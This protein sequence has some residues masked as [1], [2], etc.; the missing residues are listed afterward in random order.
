MDYNNILRSENHKKDSLVTYAVSLHFPQEI[1]EIVISTVKSISE[2]TGNSFIIENKIPPHITIGAFHASKQNEK[3]LL[4]LVEEFS[5]L[6][7]QV[8]FNSKE[9]E[10]SMEKFF[11]CN[12]KKTDFLQ[13]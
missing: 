13:K 10:T 12:Q 5:K 6:K 7:R 1:N 8:L 11:S 4:W 2:I 3:K 9:S